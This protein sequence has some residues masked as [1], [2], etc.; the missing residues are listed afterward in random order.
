MV[1]PPLPQKIAKQILVQTREIGNRS[2]IISQHGQALAMIGHMLTQAR[3][4]TVPEQILF[5]QEMHLDSFE[6]LLTDGIKLR[7]CVLV[8]TG[9]AFDHLSAKVQQILVLVVEY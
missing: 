8:R 7:R 5:S 9:G 3:I 4:S 1:Q 6:Q 2:Q